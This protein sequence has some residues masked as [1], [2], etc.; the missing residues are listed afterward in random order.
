MVWADTR[1]G[2][3]GPINQ[4]IGVRAPAGRARAGDLPLAAR[5]ARA[6]SR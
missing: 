1:L 4:K 3:F 2:E 6:A 5:R